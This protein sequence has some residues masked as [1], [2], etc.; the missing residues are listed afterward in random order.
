[1]RWRLLRRVMRIVFITRKAW[2]WG[3]GNDGVLYSSFWKGW[4]REKVITEDDKVFLWIYC[5]S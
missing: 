2:G 3:H 5:T 1:M 4:T